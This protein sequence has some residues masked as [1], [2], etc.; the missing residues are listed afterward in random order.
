MQNLF[1]DANSV[2]LAF[3]VGTFCLCFAL[4]VLTIIG[5]TIFGGMERVKA[6]LGQD[7]KG[8]RTGLIGLVSVCGMFLIAALRLLPSG[9]GGH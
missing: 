2:L 1:S 8:A 6:V 3:A 5:M 4:G 7:A 9:K